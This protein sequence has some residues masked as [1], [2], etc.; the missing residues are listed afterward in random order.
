MVPENGNP[1]GL[2]L[3]RTG[4]RVPTGPSLNKVPREFRDR[5]FPIDTTQLP[6]PP[7]ASH[8]PEKSGHVGERT[9]SS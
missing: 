4:V 9:V 1:D 5:P 6:K 7:E 8:S 3:H 2:D